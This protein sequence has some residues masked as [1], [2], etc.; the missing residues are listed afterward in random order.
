M[1]PRQSTAFPFHTL[2]SRVKKRDEPICL[3]SRSPVPQLAM[4]R[5]IDKNTVCV[6]VM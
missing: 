2:S 1:L 5:H 6:R 4:R 3:C